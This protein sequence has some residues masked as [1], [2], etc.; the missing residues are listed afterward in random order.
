[1]PNYDYQCAAC[2]YEFEEFQKM[3]DASLTE[4]PSCHKDSLKRKIGMGA[5]MIFKGSGF[6][7]T[8][9]KKSNS[10]P[11]TTKAPSKSSES[12]TEKTS[13]ESKSEKKSTSTE[14]PKS[15]S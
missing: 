6:Y 5:G 13:T 7:L 15:E 11:S 2:G 10:S 8:D 12:T 1:M 9:Y 4:C 14:S 3:S